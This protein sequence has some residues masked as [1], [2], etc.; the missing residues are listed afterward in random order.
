M[1]QNG[2]CGE[3]CDNA[4]VQKALAGY[5]AAIDLWTYQGEQW[6]A[7]FNV[8]LVANSIV[9]AGAM[10]ARPSTAADEGSTLFVGVFP[11]LLPIAGLALCVA[12]WLLIEHE[13]AWA[14]YY[15]A[16]AREL[17]GCLSPC[18][19]TVSRGRCFAQGK[20]VRIRNEPGQT[21]MRWFERV[22]ARHIGRSV[23]A[24]FF[25]LY[26]FL[27]LEQPLLLTQLQRLGSA[28]HPVTGG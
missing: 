15:V 27:L 14:M 1:A 7:R 11:V 12:W 26:L 4:R 13:R 22:P 21:Q 28:I 24:V 2:S 17:E 6:W 8:M 3:N 20:E 16:S 19:E 9:I 18:V 10:L 25:L 23:I 5:Q